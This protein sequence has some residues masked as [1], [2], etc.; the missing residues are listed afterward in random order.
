MTTKAGYWIG[1]G[2]IA[3]SV[4][5][6]IAWGVMGFMR[7]A[8]TVEDFERIPIPGTRTLL[9]EAEKVILYVEG[10]GADEL[11]PPVRVTVTDARSEARGPDRVLRR[12]PDL[13]LRCDGHGRRDGDAT[14]S[15]V[16]R[17]AHGEREHGRL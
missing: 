5:G 9:L 7:I 17:R 10:P 6:A 2:L 1:G 16:L 12:E 8:Q 13:Q 15:R 14:A 11:T 3:F 4:V